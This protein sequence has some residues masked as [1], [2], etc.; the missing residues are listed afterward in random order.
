MSPARCSR[1]LDWL[2]DGLKAQDVFR[3]VLDPIC[4]RVATWGLVNLSEALS[5]M[6]AGLPCQACVPG[7]EIVHGG[8]LAIFVNT[9]VHMYSPR[10]GVAHIDA[11]AG[12]ATRRER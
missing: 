5:Q 9:S 8:V 7:L 6:R 10:E 11:R 4:G 3:I 1:T 2:R 12:S